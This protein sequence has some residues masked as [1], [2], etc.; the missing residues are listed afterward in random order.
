MKT[1]ARYVAQHRRDQAGQ[2]RKPRWIAVEVAE[3]GHRGAE[4]AVV[5][6]SG[7]RVEV[8]RGFD[9]GTLRELVAALERA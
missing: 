7:R 1:L 2:S 6:A 4:L 5:L 9:A 3:Q 8:R